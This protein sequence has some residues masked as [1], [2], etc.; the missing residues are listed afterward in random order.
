MLPTPWKQY[1]NIFT[2]TYKSKPKTNKSILQESS[3][4]AT[5]KKLWVQPQKILRIL[6][7]YIQMSIVE[8]IVCIYNYTCLFL[9]LHFYLH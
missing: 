7:T 6:M 5:Q 8:F 9:F 1:T 4:E 2:E 3:G